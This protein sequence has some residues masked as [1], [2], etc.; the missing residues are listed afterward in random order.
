MSHLLCLGHGYV[1]TH[2]T[3]ILPNDWKV[4]GTKQHAPEEAATDKVQLIAY[5]DLSKLDPA[6]ITHILISI[7]TC[8]ADQALFQEQLAFAKRCPNLTWVAYLSV[9]SVYGNTEGEWVDETSPYKTAITEKIQQRI[10]MEKRWLGAYK[11]DQLPVHIF[12][13]TGIYGKGRSVFDRIAKE[14]RVMRIFKEGHVLSRIHIEDL[15]RCLYASIK[16]PTPGEI[17]NISDNLPA[18]YHE[19][20]GYGYELLGKEPPALTPYEKAA[21][22]ETVKHYYQ[23]FRRVSNKKIL[24]RFGI[25]LQYPTYKE[26]L[27]AINSDTIS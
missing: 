17:Y 8:D 20:I 9:T 13:L 4:T 11:N 22:P 14:G 15:V 7:P 26:G 12:R 27:Q 23:A 21:I 6:N 25:T 3:K 1:A 2:L 10:D 16:E 18:P 24:D 19:V 5:H